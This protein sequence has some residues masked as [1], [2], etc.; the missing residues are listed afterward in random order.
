MS[1]PNTALRAVRA[2]LRMSQDDL[3]RA[4]RAAGDQAGEPNECTKRLVQR[5]ESGQVTTPRG[6]YVRALEV[7]TGHPIE[8]LGFT[9]ADE[10]Y[11][12]N[13]G[14]A[15]GMAPTAGL[16]VGDRDVA[17]GPLTGIWRS[18]YEYVSSGRGGQTFVSEH[19]V[20]LLHRGARLQVRS[21]PGTAPGRC[22][23]DLTVNGQ[24]VTGTWTEQTNPDGYYQG[25]VYSGAIQ[26][27]LEPTGHRMSGKWVGFGRDFDVN[28]GPWTLELV[29]A[30]TGK[31]TMDEYN[32]PVEAAES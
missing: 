7:A 12:L 25:S 29:S 17:G 28:D 9:P 23:M 5:W 32:R 2:S 30:D 20:I 16:A 19:Y 8:N 6:V 4:V 31:E 24:V 3:A 11:G 22:M 27:L 1:E 15:L 14:E 18:R 13:R 10:R 26:M 21:L